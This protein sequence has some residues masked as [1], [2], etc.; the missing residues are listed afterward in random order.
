[1]GCSVTQW[2]NNGEPSRL[3]STC[4]TLRSAETWV[5]GVHQLESIRK[6]VKRV[7]HETGDVTTGRP[8][9]AREDV[10]PIRMGYHL[11]PWVLLLCSITCLKNRYGP[12]N[13]TYVIKGNFLRFPSPCSSW[14][15]NDNVDQLYK[16]SSSLDWWRQFNGALAGT[17]WHMIQAWIGLY[18]CH[19]SFQ[20]ERLMEALWKE[21]KGKPLDSCNVNRR[22]H[23]HITGQMTL[24][25]FPLYI[26]CRVWTKGTRR[27]FRIEEGLRFT[28]TLWE[29]GGE[30]VERGNLWL[31]TWMC[32]LII[33]WRGC[34][35]FPAT[36]LYVP[37]LSSTSS[38]RN[39][40]L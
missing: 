31:F 32:S 21:R 14:Q 36:P 15:M 13:S 12:R 24:F 35:D 10:D 22:P 20:K 33:T 34:W 29:G 39:D 7:A 26:L 2:M 19:Q 9:T 5:P 11:V 16:W 8:S 17:H 4:P 18:V 25:S 6:E 3:I 1:M 23:S 27:P 37:S 40:D 38:V 30:Q 28:H